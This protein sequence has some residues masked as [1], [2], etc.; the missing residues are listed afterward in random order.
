[1]TD[2]RGVDGSLPRPLQSSVPPTMSVSLKLII[3]VDDGIANASKFI[4]SLIA[5]ITGNPVA[6]SVALPSVTPPAKS[7]NAKKAVDQ[8]SSHAVNAGVKRKAEQ[9]L[10]PSPGKALKTSSNINNGISSTR[11]LSSPALAK[12]KSP[13]KLSPP[14]VKRQTP[15][16]GSPAPV[17]KDTPSK[18]LPA[19]ATKHTPPKTS[20]APVKK[21]TSPKTL[22]APVK[23]DTLPKTLSAS[24]PTQSTPQASQVKQAPQASQATEAPPRKGTFADT[25]ARAQAAQAM[26][27]QIGAIKHK[28]VEKMTPKEHKAFIAQIKGKKATAKGARAMGSKGVQKKSPTGNLQRAGP[29]ASSAEKGKGA[30]AASEPTKKDLSRLVAKE[31]D[32]KGTARPPR[33]E[34]EYKGTARPP[35]SFSSVSARRNRI[36]KS[37]QAAKRPVSRRSAVRSDPDEDEDDEEEEEDVGSAGSSDMEA[38]AF[39]VEEE[40]YSSLKTA[41]AEDEKALREEMELKK[42]KLER[43]RIL[44]ALAAKRR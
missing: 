38:A 28:P 37:R 7:D 31:L 33:V 11:A 17:K 5:G 19:P 3:L 29:R 1:M 35:G 44:Q 25:L 9:E 27:K 42:K 41:K 32:Y 18:T 39:E 43:K 22:P 20:P 2:V 12:K 4:N 23:K 24:A 6:P 21:E 14:P 8:T 40:E 36:Q 30:P 10:G 13:A 34:T 26:A 15:P 16:K